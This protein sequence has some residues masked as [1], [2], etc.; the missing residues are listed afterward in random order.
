[1]LLSVLVFAPF[2]KP[3]LPV[4]IALRLAM[5]PVI[6]GISYEVLRFTA[7]HREKALIRWL[8]APNLA[9]QRLTTREPDDA[10]LEVAIQAL[11][12]VLDGERRAADQIELVG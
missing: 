10:M 11:R 12:S 3:P 4:R 5:L 1:M 7:R 2:G 8:I 6:S 9:L